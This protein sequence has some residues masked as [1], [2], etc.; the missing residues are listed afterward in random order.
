MASAR[1]WKNRP[2]RFMLDPRSRSTVTCSMT[3]SRL[4]DRS[5]E[6]AASILSSDRAVLISFP[7]ASASSQRRFSSLS[8]ST[9]RKIASAFCN[10]SSSRICC[11]HTSR[12]HAPSM[13]RSSA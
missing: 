8:V 11:R 7:M 12:F 10:G 13:G 2:T 9:V 5:S 1:S 6:A 4:N 3:E